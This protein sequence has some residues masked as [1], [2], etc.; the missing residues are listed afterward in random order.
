MPAGKAEHSARASAESHGQ[1]D[2]TDHGPGRPDG[3]GR[4]RVAAV[5]RISAPIET[6]RLTL[7]PFAAGDLD[8]LYAYLSSADVVQ[9]MYWQARDREQTGEALQ[10]RIGQDRLDDEHDYLALAVVQR[11]TGRVAGEVILK[12]VSREHRQGEVGFAFNPDHHGRGYAAEAATAMLGLAFGVLGLHRVVGRCDPRNLASA[13][14]LERLGMRLEAHFVHNE[15]FK[16]EWGDELYYAL[17]EDEWASR[18][19]RPDGLGGWR[20]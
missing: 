16:G 19:D 18:R 9:Y 8:D 4:V 17:L 5:L 10:T 20:R 13:R 12:W 15:I 14:V 6:D 2:P 3:G 11:E 7:R 1:A